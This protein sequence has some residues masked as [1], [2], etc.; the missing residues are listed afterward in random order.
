VPSPPVAAVLLARRLRELRLNHWPDSPI[1]QA[2]LAAALSSEQQVG[3]AT[4]SSWESTSGPKLPPRTRLAAYARLFATRRS[5]DGEPHLVPLD[6]LTPDEETSRS[7]LERELLTL[8]E[9]VRRPFEEEEVA[10]RRS[11]QF[12]DSGPLTIICPDVPGK[13]LGA[14]ASPE[15]PNYIEMLSYADLDALI[16]LFGHIRA[17]NPGMDVF[18]KLASGVVADDL[19]GHVVLLGGVAWNDVTKRFLELITRIPIQ[20][21]DD[22]QLKTGDIFLVN[23][24]QGERRFY[25]RWARDD[26]TELVE[27]VGLFARM[28]NPFNV[29]RSLTI[30]NGIHS[31]GV[32]GAVRCLTDA[33]VR[34][35]NENYLASR[36]PRGADYAL[37]LRVPV[38][39]GQALSPDLHNQGSRLYE[40]P[41]SGMGA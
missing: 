10:V 19:S 28:R 41:S 8:Y 2:Q 34:D 15:H 6:E 33:R 20:Q 39:K 31:R 29:N 32:L 14:M 21:I 40:W 4:V 26:E 7:E 38:I 13:A 35:A 24:P 11:W 25:P 9:D 22:P 16:E 17:E 23:E 36:F 30:C 37:L 3:A 27:D 18:H 5:L 1:T 12:A